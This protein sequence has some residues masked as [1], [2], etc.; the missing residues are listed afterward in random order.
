M[1]NSEGTTTYVTHV[2]TGEVSSSD[3]KQAIAATS[4]IPQADVP[5]LW[6][7]RELDVDAQGGQLGEILPDLIALAKNHMS[8]EKRAFVLANHAGL[9]WLESILGRAHAPWPWVVFVDMDAAVSW[10]DP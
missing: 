1:I 3:I 5:I 10:L 8:T 6:D 4:V 7:L 2:V 9:E